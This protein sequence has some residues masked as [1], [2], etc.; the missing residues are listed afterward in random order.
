[1][2]RL[3]EHTRMAA[4]AA[5]ALLA[6]LSLLAVCITAA[7]AQDVQGPSLSLSASY[8]GDF[9]RNTTGGLRTG[10]A[11]DDSLDLGLVW[12]TEGLFSDARMTTNLSVM[13]LAGGRI[14]NDYVGDLQGVN[15]LEASEGWRLYESWV[16][17]S[18]GDSRSSLRA[19][20]LDMNAEFDTPVTQ[21]IFTSSP[22]GIGTE[23][24][25]TGARGPVCWPT[26][27][28]GI[29]VA[30]EISDRMHWRMGA[31]DGAPGTPTDRA[32]TST[33]LSGDDGALIVGELEYASGRI[34]KLAVGGW[35]YTSAF[36]RLDGAMSGE[37]RRERGNQGFYAHFDARLATAGTLNLNGSIRAGVAQARFNP[38]DHYV[39]VGFSAS[40]FSAARAGDTLALGVA[41]AHLGNDYRRA[42]AFAGSPTTSAETLFELVYRAE[43][44]SWLSV[45]PSV[46]FVSS[47]GADPQ[48]ND[49]WVAGLRF[50]L[51]RDRSWQLNARRESEPE[52]SY[53]RTE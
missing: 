39:G 7:S 12:V 6:G 36:E 32:F 2:A 15:T 11:Y 40:G 1:M 31:Y 8:T 29:R 53:A 50:E 27:G 25:Q 13:H 37:L 47:P 30:G 51:T 21:G 16:E 46:Q 35:S 23:F 14:S 20:V 45:L 34:N 19:G 41:L 5:W 24:S 42:S 44:T 33:R 10:D 18:F 9:R 4:R 17:L 48:A 52:G 28:L 43:L 3:R 22:F 49:A 26:T 38:V